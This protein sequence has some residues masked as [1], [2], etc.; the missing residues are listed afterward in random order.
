MS[1]LMYDKALLDRVGLL[2]PMVSALKN[3]VDHVGF[4]MVGEVGL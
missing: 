1:P 2:A 4:L 3:A